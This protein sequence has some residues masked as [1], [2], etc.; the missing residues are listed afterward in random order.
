MSSQK[1]YTV[2]YTEEQVNRLFNLL[3]EHPWKLSQDLITLLQQSATAANQPEAK[4]APHVEA[5]A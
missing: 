5:A 1:T 4:D 2:E 3:S